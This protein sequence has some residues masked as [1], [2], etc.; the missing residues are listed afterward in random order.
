[1]TYYCF[2]WTFKIYFKF[3]QRFYFNLKLHYK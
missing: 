2:D 1:M 3:S